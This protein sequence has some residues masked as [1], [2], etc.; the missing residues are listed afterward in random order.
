M[1][2]YIALLRGINVG[3][4]KIIPMADLKRVFEKLG[5]DD[6]K[7]YIQSGN[8][9]FGSPKKEPSRLEQVITEGI[10]KHF[11]IDVKNIVLSKEELEKIIER[12]PFRQRK[13]DGDGRIYFTMMMD[14]PSRER[15]PALEG[16]K[17]EI[18][19]ASGTEDDFRVVGRTIYVLCRNGWSKSP[20][21]SSTTEKILK[22][23]TTSRNLETIEKLI[24]IARKESL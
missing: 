10:N 6:V 5:F 24:A 14:S 23:D 17:K 4:N 22:V 11:G 8:V 9:V 2:T 20:F 21:N 16:I 12:N 1:K 3:G 19:M 15:L 7:T 18:A 13:T